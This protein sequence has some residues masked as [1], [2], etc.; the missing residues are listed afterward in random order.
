M[1]TVAKGITSG[2]MPLGAVIAN[3]RVRESCGRR[4][5]RLPPRLQYS[6]HPTAC[7]VALENL[8]I[9][10]REGSATG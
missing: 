8:A 4:R 9:I 2:Y 7:A 10:D 5:R 3:E 6:G 1:I